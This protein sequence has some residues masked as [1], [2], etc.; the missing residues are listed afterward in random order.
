MYGKDS[1]NLNSYKTILSP[2]R[3]PNHPMKDMGQFQSGI[4]RV[5][6]LLNL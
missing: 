6:R 2:I 5:I 3:G 1:E 4:Y